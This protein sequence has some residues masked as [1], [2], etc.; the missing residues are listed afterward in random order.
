MRLPIARVRF[1]TAARNQSTIALEQLR[2]PGRDHLLGAVERHRRLELSVRQLRQMLDRSGNARVAFDLVV[3]R[4]E[5]CVANRPVDRDAVLRVRLEIE[6]AQ[7][8]A[9]TSPRE[10]PSADVIAAIPVE[11]LDLGVRR[12]FLRHPPVEI[13]LVQRIVA[14]Q[15]RIPFDHLARA[16]TAMRILPRRFA[17]V[18]VI[19]PV[20][21]VLAAF[22]HQH[23]QAALRQLF[24]GP[25]PGDAGADDDRVEPFGLLGH[26]SRDS[27]AAR[28]SISPALVGVCSAVSIE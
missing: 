28:V 26:I 21:D 10:R 25:A 13:L 2:E 19:L 1:A 18:R 24:G 27:T 7:A 17:R 6:I 14:L 8:I 23:A 12:V 3:P 20:L 5:V 15:D 9:L 22:E 11:A 16:A 4:R